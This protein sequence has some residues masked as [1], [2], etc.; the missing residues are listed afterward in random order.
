VDKQRRP[1]VGRALRELGI[2]LIPAYSPQARGRS[3]RSF[4]PLAGQ[5]LDRIFSLQHTRV[6]NRDNTVQFEHLCLQIEPVEWRGTL[7]GCQVTVHQHL[8]GTLS[9]RYGQH[10]L[11]RYTAQGRTI[12][13]TATAKTATRRM[14]KT[15]ARPPWKS[16]RDSHAL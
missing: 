7:A 6:V 4:G 8:D 10:R 13:T 9:L 3:E 1:Q 11:G 15:A 5:D 12:E 16:L 2:Q 14:E